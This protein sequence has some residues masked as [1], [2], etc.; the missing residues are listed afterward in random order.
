MTLEWKIK[1]VDEL[2]REDPE[3]T[4]YDYLKLIAELMQ[5]EKAT[6]IDEFINHRLR[7]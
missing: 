6:V 4:I 1:I 7:A 5:I 3:A 2:I